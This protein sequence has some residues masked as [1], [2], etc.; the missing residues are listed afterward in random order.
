MKSSTRTITMT[1]LEPGLNRR[2][3]KDRMKKMGH[4]AE[5]LKLATGVSKNTINKALSPGSNPNWNTISPILFVLKITDL[6][7]VTE[8]TNRLLPAA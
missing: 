4:T 6:N 3:I 8:E 7:Q 5:T 1:V 2:L